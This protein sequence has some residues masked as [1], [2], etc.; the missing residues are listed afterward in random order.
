[1]TGNVITRAERRQ[2]QIH[3]STFT[4]QQE[5]IIQNVRKLCF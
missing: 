5:N 4:K 3:V 2:V 1:M